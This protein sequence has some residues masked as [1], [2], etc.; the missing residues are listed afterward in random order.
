MNS[1]SKLLYGLIIGTPLL[2]G[3]ASGEDG[4][5]GL[6]GTSSSNIITDSNFSVAFSDFEPD[7]IE[8]P[9]GTL[10]GAPT[11]TSF[12]AS[13]IVSTTAN[14]TTDITAIAGDRQNAKVTSGTVNIRVEWGLI[15]N[16]T[17]QLDSSG[18]CSVEW[19]SITNLAVL[20]DGGGNVDLV[21]NVT[22]WIMGEESFVDSNGNGTFDDGETFTD[23]DEPFL[24]I[25]NNGVFDAGDLLIDIDNNNVHTP[26]NGLYNR[27]SCQHSSLCSTTTRIPIYDQSYIFLGYDAS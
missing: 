18:Q 24:D 14:V 3:C 1:T 12:P 15:D 6:S 7:V 25:N 10:A 8:L 19:Q 13:N 21:N 9:A 27:S 2:F 16:S 11:T 26:E 20:T 23:V 17:C 4:F 5:S 22:V